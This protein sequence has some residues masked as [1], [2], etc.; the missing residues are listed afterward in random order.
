MVA[1]IQDKGNSLG[2]HLLSLMGEERIQIQVRRRKVCGRGRT[3]GR[4]GRKVWEV[5]VSLFMRPAA[6]ENI[7]YH[8]HSW[9]SANSKTIF[10]YRLESHFQSR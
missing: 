3:P 2:F 7:L 8:V 5:T 4:Q 6:S 1:K 10:Y 9:L